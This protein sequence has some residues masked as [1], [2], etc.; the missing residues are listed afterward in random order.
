[1]KFRW[2]RHEGELQNITKEQVRWMLSG[3]D[4]YPKKYFSE[5]EYDEK[6]MAI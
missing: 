4:I 2:P 6:K 3:L 5:I 1:M